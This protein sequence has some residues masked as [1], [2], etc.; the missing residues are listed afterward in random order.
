MSRAPSD[1]A[2]LM[3]QV[4]AGSVDAFGELYDRFSDRAYRVARSVC[5]DDDRA[6][7][8]VHDAFVS[9]WRGRSGYCS[10]RGTVAAWLLSAVRH[11]AIDLERRSRRHASR[12]VG[13]ELL[14]G[15]PATDDIS[16]QAVKRA[17]AEGLRA[18]L[19][20]LPDGQ[21][22][23]VTLAFY[24]Q[25]SYT[26]IAAHLGLPAG[27]VKGRMRLGLQKLRAAIRQAAA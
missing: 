5:P 26:E 2:E 11:R 17:E 9:V 6:Q 8:A 15:L 27:T 16:D 1:D 4:S 25:L 18:T 19:A 21:R 10:Q 12:H 13:P 22:E 20:R 23:V 7:D 14:D 3:T 24:G